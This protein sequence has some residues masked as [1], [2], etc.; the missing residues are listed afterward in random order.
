MPDVAVRVEL[1]APD[2]STWAW[3][4]ETDEV[5]RGSALDFCRVVTQR[6]HPDDTG[7]D[8]RGEA[9]REWISIAQAFAGRPTEQRPPASP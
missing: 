6:R 1:E 4:D 2:G 3:G 9:A 7:L 5:V 8:V